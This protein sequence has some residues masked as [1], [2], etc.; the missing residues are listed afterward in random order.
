VYLPRRSHFIRTIDNRE[1]PFLVGSDES[2]FLESLIDGVIRWLLP[3]PTSI[4]HTPTGQE[5]PAPE[6]KGHRYEN[7]RVDQALS[8]KLNSNVVIFQDIIMTAT[9]YV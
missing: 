1:L 9:N 8:S 2:D 3:V 6:G 4:V 5:G 7:E